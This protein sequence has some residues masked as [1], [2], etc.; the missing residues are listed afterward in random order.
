V[1]IKE[2]AIPNG[3]SAF[4]KPTKIGMEE[5]EQNGVTAPKMAD[6]KLPTPNFCLANISLILCGGKNVRI[7]AMAVIITRIKRYIFTVS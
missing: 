5:Q 2:K 4:K 1:I 7:K 6:E 3:I